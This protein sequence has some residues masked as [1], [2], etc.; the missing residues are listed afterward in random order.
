MLI[1]EQLFVNDMN[2]EHEKNHRVSLTFCVSHQTH[3]IY[4]Q[5]LDCVTVLVAITVNVI[6]TRIVST[7]LKQNN[8]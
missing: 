4:V 6:S 2:N 5:L 1:F 3:P 8:L 7:H